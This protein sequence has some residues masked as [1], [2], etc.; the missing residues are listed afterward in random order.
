V[1]GGIVLV[2]IL[3]FVFTHT[4]DFSTLVAT[5]V[6]FGTSLFVVMFASLSSAYEY[7]KNGHVVMRAVTFIGTVSIIAALGASVVAASLQGKT[8]QS[9]FAIVV[10]SAAVRL[11]LEPGKARRDEKVNLSAGPM[12]LIGCA[13][14]L[15]SSLAGV[16]GGVFSIP[17]MYYLLRFP[18]K[19][20]LGSSSAAIV[21]TSM[22]AT[23]GY[24]IN[25]LDDPDIERYSFVIGYVDYLHAIPVIAGT[26]PMA[27]LGANVAHRLSSD[28]LRRLFALFLLVVAVKMFFT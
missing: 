7:Y 18:M 23:L 27:G 16:G 26:I 28:K 5:H 8:L 25:G 10:A 17:M 19:K 6:T 1:G 15:V 20:A 24:I 22:A 21:L 9:I 2:P 12:M 4:L 3:L 13:A 14:G 11:L